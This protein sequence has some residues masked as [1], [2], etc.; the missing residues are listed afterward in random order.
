[1]KNNRRNVSEKAKWYLQAFGYVHSDLAFVHAYVRVCRCMCCPLC[2]MTQTRICLITFENE[3]SMTSF[4]P[5]A[6]GVVS[7][8]TNF[9]LILLLITCNVLVAILIFIICLQPD[10]KSICRLEISIQKQPHTIL[11]LFEVIFALWEKGGEPIKM[12]KSLH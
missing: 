1:M 7:R 6:W 8:S 4:T 3:T 11:N 9:A 2:E 5:H 10:T 12:L